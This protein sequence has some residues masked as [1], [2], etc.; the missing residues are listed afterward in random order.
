MKCKKCGGLL[1]FE[2]IYDGQSQS[3]EMERCVNCSFQTDEVTEMNRNGPPP[4]GKKCSARNSSKYVLQKKRK[5]RITK[6]WCL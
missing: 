1:F 2:K 6:Q 5:G 3:V 4:V